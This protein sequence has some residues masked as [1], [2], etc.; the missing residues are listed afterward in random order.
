MNIKNFEEYID[1]TIQKRGYKYY[2]D[3]NIYDEYEQNDDEYKFEVYGTQDYTVTV[4]LNRNG[5]IVYS[6]CDCPYDYGPTCKHEVAVYYKL[7]ELLENSNFQDKIQKDKTSKQNN[8]TKTNK[9]SKNKKLSFEEILQTLNKQQMIDI[10]RYASVN[11]STIENYIILKYSPFDDEAEL[12]ICRKMMKSIV[13]K[14]SDRYGYIEWK[15]VPL[16][17]DEIGE[18]LNRAEAIQNSVLAIDILLMLL[19]E[20]FKVLSHADDSDGFIGDFINDIFFMINQITLDLKNNN[21]EATINKIFDKILATTNSHVFCGWE[22][23]KKDLFDICC[24]IAYTEELRE[25]L[26]L[27]ITRDMKNINRDYYGEY[28]SKMYLDSIYKMISLYG[29]DQE[30]EKFL[31]EHIDQGDFLEF[32]IE[33]YIKNKQFDKAL[34]LISKLEQDKEFKEY[35]LDEL[36]YKIYKAD[37][38]VEKQQEIAKILLLKGKMK[39]YDELKELSNDE[40]FFKNIK[41]ELKD[42]KAINIWQFINIAEKESDL[43]EILAYVKKY[44]SDIERFMGML[45]VKYKDEVMEIYETFIKELAQYASNRSRYR[46]VCSKIRTY[47]KLAGKDKKNEIIDELKALYKKKPAFMDELSKIK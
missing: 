23:Y 3:E 21:D 5:D 25:K 6:N 47:K 41:Q 38:Q 2:T 16:F 20:G 4:K 13:R 34:N 29:N 40:N 15:K 22:P 46:E 12:E 32:L 45:K 36:R 31:Y 7:R 39:Y 43:E 30:V 28:V 11:N 1:T 26:N 24:N 44:P 14:Y 8:N 10:I 27:K 33:K 42:C 18:L 17:T 9:K 37:N 19:E 35:S